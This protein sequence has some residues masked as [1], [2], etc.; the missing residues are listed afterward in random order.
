MTI[1]FTI[2]ALAFRYWAEFRK[3]YIKANATE[4]P[5]KKGKY[6]GTD[7]WWPAA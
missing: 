2:Q 5:K 7:F 3:D 1:F 6:K 4:A